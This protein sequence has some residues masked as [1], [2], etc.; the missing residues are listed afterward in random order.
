MLAASVVLTLLCFDVSGTRGPRPP[1]FLALP[2]V[3]GLL[4]GA[5]GLLARRLALGVTTGLV[6]VFAV[7]VAMVMTTLVAGP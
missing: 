1:W 4:G 5:A 7:P 2:A 6:G 3:C